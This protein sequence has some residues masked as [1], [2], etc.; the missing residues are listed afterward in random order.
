MKQKKKPVR[1]WRQ[2]EQRERKNPEDSKAHWHK[3][4][5][6]VQREGSDRG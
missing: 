2:G 5:C 6:N 3:S 4:P 1:Y